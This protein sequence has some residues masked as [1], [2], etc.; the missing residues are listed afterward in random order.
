MYNFLLNIL[1]ISLET[2]LGE[3]LSFF[4]YDSVKLILLLFVMIFLIGIIRTYLPQNKLKIWL[5]KKGF[6][7]YI[8][9]ALFGSI[10]PFCSCSSIPIFIGMVMAGIPLGVVFSFLITSPLIDKYIV[11]VMLGSFGLKI[12][13]LYIVSGI[14]IGIFSGIIIGKLK[15]EKYIETDLFN[16][17]IKNCN[18][19]NEA[20]SF[21]NFKSRVRFG[22]SEAIEITKKIWY[23]IVIGVGIGALI[24]NYIPQNS[25]ETIINKTGILGVPIAVVLGVPMYGNCAAIVPIALV[26]FQKGVPL[27]TAL[28]FMMSIAA[29]SLPAAILLRRAIKLKL[30]IIFFSVTT[31]GIIITGYLF[32]I[33][34]NILLL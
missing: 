19:N 32:N 33:I 1:G 31:L 23:W 5:N 34:Q 21:V 13:L 9:G 17:N 6:K 29:L 8:F 24:Y 26:L 2:K 7:A 28:S 22:Y 16:N 18:A 14:I 20:N 12:T 27:G 11:I 15:L 30:I 3:T 4:I 25:I 10:T